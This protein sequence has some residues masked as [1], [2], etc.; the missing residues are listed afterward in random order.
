MRTQASMQISNTVNL[1]TSLFVIGVLFL[2]H[3]S[4]TSKYLA[5]PSEIGNIIVYF[6]I[7]G[8]VY[9]SAFKLT[10]AKLNSTFLIFWLSRII[11]IIPLYTVALMGFYILYYN[12]SNPINIFFHILGLKAIFPELLGPTYIAMYFVAI[13]LAYYL[14]FSITKQLLSKRRVFILCSAF[15]YLAILGVRMY[16]ESDYKIF[17]N[18]FV[19]YFPFFV[20][21]MLTATKKSREEH[22]LFIRCILISIPS[23]V[24]LSL[25]LHFMDASK[26]IGFLSTALF[27]ATA[28]I[29]LHVLAVQIRFQN[30]TLVTVAKH[31][32]YASFSMYLFHRIIWYGMAL[33]YNSHTILQW[34]YIVVIGTPAI[35]CI[36]YGIQ[37][38][39]DQLTNKSRFH[40]V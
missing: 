38:G 16:F 14:F 35:F 34:F 18:A 7:G 2:H 39:Y 11:R 27:A 21:G 19:I 1:L 25:I 31:I 3:S 17:H 24:F 4:Y 15:T 30:K 6:C 29:P 10:R 8:F 37:Y 26:G 22:Y 23:I 32:A 5:V 36:S 12:G 9:I 13:L 40:Q 20:A 33:L 28:M